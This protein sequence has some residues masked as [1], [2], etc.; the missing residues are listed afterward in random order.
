MSQKAVTVKDVKIKDSFWSPIQDLVMDF[1]LPYQADI[2]EDKADIEVKSHAV[3]NFRIA[4]GE[5][6]GEF[7]GMVFQDSDVAK[8][9]EAVAYALTVKSNPDL[10]KRADEI[11]A[12]IGRAQEEDGYLNTFFTVK[13]PEHKWLNLQECH[14]LYC[15]G[16]MIEA[17]VA[18]YEATGKDELLKIMRRNADL[19][20]SRF[21]PPE[22]GKLRGIPGHQEIELALM[23]L[24]YIT[25]EK[26]YLE[27]A[28]YFLD[29][30]GREP[31]F[32]AEEAAKL[33][34]HHFGMKPE[35]REYAQNHLPAKEQTEAVGHSVRAV[36]MYAA[37]AALAAET[38]DEEWL[39][40][41]RT[42]WGNIVNKR[43]YI[44]GGIGSTVA[45]EAFSIDYDLPNDTVYAETCASVAM[46]FFARYMLEIEPKGEYADIMEKMLYNGALSGMQ[47]D[48]RRFFYV[49]PL[50]VVPGV[51]GKLFG[52]KHVLPKRPEWYGCACCPPNLARLITSL[53]Q[54]AWAQSDDT[55]YCHLYVGGLAELNLADINVET[56]YPWDGKVKIAFTQKN[57]PSYT[58]AIRI[59]GWC[60][61]WTLSLNGQPVKA[62]VKD[63]YAY[64]TRE[65]ET[66]DI[67]ELNL[68]MEPKRMYANTAVR[69]DIGTVALQRGP[70]V[71]CLE[72]VD[73]GPNLAALH[74]PRDAKLL[75]KK[76]NLKGLGDVV[77]IEA[78]GLRIESSS[79][80]YSDTPPQSKPAILRAVPYYSWGNRESGGMRVWIHE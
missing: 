14:E 80:L 60:K 19:I 41:C 8:W 59:P 77:L 26:S 28:Q 56:N 64:I 57:N 61:D 39:K 66:G 36:Y 69:A 65:W 20:C 21:G 45:G 70:I 27:T 55:V 68:P 16:H 79:D 52:H 76:T 51:S 23:R 72:E 11:I 1:M 29:E 74:L 47:Q 43:M 33:D 4:A 17:A 3:Q 67:V 24:Y 78:E 12:L 34:W 32:F 63:G 53:G 13:Q 40:A 10:E 30:R 6:E 58:F 62:E 46:V 48:G 31:N 15:S 7:H 54:Y 9:L 35:N 73:N 75:P 2:L 38:K 50:E 71:Y 42:L 22:T 25:G 5:A 44:T 18:Y 49:N 37:M